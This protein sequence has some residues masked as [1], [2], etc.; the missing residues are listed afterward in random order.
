MGNIVKHILF[1]LFILSVDL[2]SAQ[3]SVDSSQSSLINVNSLDTV[4]PAGKF[5]KLSGVIKTNFTTDSTLLAKGNDNY[6]ELRKSFTNSFKKIVETGQISLGYDYGFLPYTLSQSVPSNAINTEGLIALNLFNIP[7][8]ISYFYTSQKNLIGLNNY[9]RVSYNA[10]RYKNNLKS[11]LNSNVS[12]YK[13]QLST[14]TNKRQNLLQRMAYTDYLSSIS[15]EKWPS[16]SL[17]LNSSNVNADTIKNIKHDTLN[18]KS[19]DANQAKID[20][21]EKN[22]NYENAGISDKA[23]YYKHKTDSVK[24]LYESYEKEYNS[25][26]DSINVIQSRIK[27]L[28]SHLNGSETYNS[29]LGKLP[30]YTKAQSILSGIKKFEIGLCYPNYS[31]FLVNNIPVRGINIEYSKSNSYLAFTYGTTVSSVLFGRNNLE[32]FLQ[33]VRNSYNYFDFN[34]VTAGRKIIAAKLGYGTKEGTHVFLGI[35]LGK[36]RSSYLPINGTEYN[37]STKES[38]VVIEAD[39][40]YKIKKSTT[41]D[42]ILGKSS[43]QAEDLSYEIIKKSF[44][45]VFS[46]FR[47]NAILTKLQTYINPSKSNL[48]FSVRIVDPFFKSYGLGFLRSDNIRYEFKLDQFISKRIRYV[49]SFRYE[50]DNL[51][52]VLNYKNKFYSFGNTVSVKLNRRFMLRGTYTPIYRNIFSPGYKNEINNHIATGVIT[53]NPRVKKGNSQLNFIYNYYLIETDSSNIDFQNFA[54]T[55]QVN[56]NS[57]FRTGASFSWFKNTETDSINNSVLLSVMDIGYQFVSGSSVVIGGKAAFKSE[58][59]IYPGF[60]AKVNLKLFKGFFWETQFEKF[61]IGDLFNGYDLENLKK[62][63]YYCSTRLVLNF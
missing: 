57:G 23:S 42:I 59:D 10:D 43:I 28:E 32:G 52:N 21:V 13:G 19:I 27:E 53:Y 62:F 61:V 39:I 37:F 46:S 5:D 40:R 63:P 1:A 36:G 17:D 58:K 22:N 29:Y 47:S 15:P 45:E 11:N 48:T 49:G 38:N 50:E 26:S 35:L 60:L 20:S 2:I 41:L 18:L 31:S 24:S 16:D 4:I 12:K 55:Y 54:F 30:F 25:T 44:D 8:D 6:K 7:I 14:L 33:N 34:N 56:F 9:F 3:V 51:L